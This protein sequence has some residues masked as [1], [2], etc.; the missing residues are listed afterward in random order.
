M[1]AALALA[2]LMFWRHPKGPATPL[3]QAP[4]PAAIEKAA[5]D[6]VGFAHSEQTGVGLAALPGDVKR[7]Y[8]GLG[9]HPGTDKV[10][11]CV[12]LDIAAN[13]LAYA[14]GNTFVPPYLKTEAMVSRRS[15]LVMRTIKPADRDAFL[16]SMDDA[17]HRADQD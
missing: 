7:C 12:I 3:D 5:A 2:S 10:A 4:S 15:K 13:K 11:Y 9:G 6:A 8:D 14:G 16:K 17:E 1:I